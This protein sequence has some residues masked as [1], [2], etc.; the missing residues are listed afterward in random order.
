MDGDVVE[1]DSVYR[2]WVPHIR[3]PLSPLM[4][5][6]VAFQRDVVCAALF[7]GMGS[8]KKVASLFQ[9]PTRWV[10]ECEKCPNANSFKFGN[11]DSHAEHLFL[12]A[13]DFLSE[14]GFFTDFMND[15]K[16]VPLDFVA[17]GEIDILFCSF[18]C[19][20][21][22]IARSGRMR[23][24]QGHEDSYQ[25]DCFWAAFERLRPKA[26]CMEQ[27]F[28]F[29]LAE[30]SEVAQSPLQKMIAKFTDDYAAYNV[31][32]FYVAGNLYT[33]LVRHRVYLVAVHEDAGGADVVSMPKKV[34][35]A[36]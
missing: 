7:D 10:L 14:D 22:S 34:V 32:V 24:T 31:A 1:R 18:S 36:T 27:V 3:K 30:P 21:Y 23:G 13:R 6:R 35:T 8:E 17:P 15:F 4:E 12:D 19:R 5:M 11:S 25:V 9:I 16:R 26:L 2:H 29:A 28:G 20:P 33:V